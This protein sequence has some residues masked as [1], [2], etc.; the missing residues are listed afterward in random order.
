MTALEFFEKWV[1]YH[2]PAE[3]MLTIGGLALVIASYIY[4]LVGFANHGIS[5]FTGKWREAAK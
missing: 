2:R 4:C 3:W 1:G 5:F